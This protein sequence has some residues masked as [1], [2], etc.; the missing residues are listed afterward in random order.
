LAQ[1]TLNSSTPASSWGITQQLQQVSTLGLLGTQVEFDFADIIIEGA[2]D[3]LL[4]LS[5]ATYT[6]L[7]SFASNSGTFQ[8][9]VLAAPQADDQAAIWFRFQLSGDPISATYHI[10]NVAIST[11]DPVTEAVPEPATLAIMAFGL[12]GLGLVTRWR[13]RLHGHH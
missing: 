4:S 3:V 7:P 10:D 5:N 9:E 1:A 6:P 2:I 13:Q 12:L 8:H 11:A